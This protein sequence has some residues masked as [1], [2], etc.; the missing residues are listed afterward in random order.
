MINSIAELEEKILRLKNQSTQLK[1]M[2]NSSYN[3]KY[4]NYS[5][6]QYYKIIEDSFSI[7]KEISINYEKL[8]RLKKI[9]DILDE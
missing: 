2:I 1:F 5:V 4:N 7:N 9:N 3:Y 8:K 6:E